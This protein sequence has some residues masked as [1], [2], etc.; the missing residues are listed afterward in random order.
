MSDAS[1]RD[2]P[3]KIIDRS[4]AIDSINRLS[5]EDCRFLNR[6]I[7]KRIKLIAQ[8]RATSLMVNFNNGDRVEFR[9]PDGT[10]LEGIVIRLNK[11]T[12]SVVTTGGHQWNVSPG[13]LNLAE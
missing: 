11:K 8:A 1:K 3:V 7:V 6:L 9:A 5:E 2:R 12:V 10:M 4:S 13:L